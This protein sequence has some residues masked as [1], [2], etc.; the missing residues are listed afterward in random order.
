MAYEK[1]GALLPEDNDFSVTQSGQNF[2]SQ[3]FETKECQIPQGILF[4]IGLFTSYC[5]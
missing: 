5:C 1:Q 4:P 2:L 3:S